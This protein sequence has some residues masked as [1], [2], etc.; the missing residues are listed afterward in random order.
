MLTTIY[1]GLDWGD[2]AMR[3]TAGSFSLRLTE[4]RVLLAAHQLLLNRPTVST[5][6]LVEAEP[7]PYFAT[8]LDFPS[9]MTNTVDYL[10]ISLNGVYAAHIVLSGGGR[11]ESLQTLELRLR[12]EVI[13]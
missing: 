8:A 5:A 13:G 7:R 11:G 2:D 3:A 10:T 4:P 9:L 6:D 12:L 1:V